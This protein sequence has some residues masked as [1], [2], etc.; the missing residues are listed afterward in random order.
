MRVNASDVIYPTFT[1]AASCFLSLVLSITEEMF[2]AWCSPTLLTLFA[3]SFDL[4]LTGEASYMDWEC[5]WKVL[6][7]SCGDQSQGNDKWYTNINVHTHCNKCTMS[8]CWSVVPPLKLIVVFMM[9]VWSGLQVTICLMPWSPYKLKFTTSTRGR[10]F[11]F[12]YKNPECCL[13]SVLSPLTGS[14]S[15]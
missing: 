9:H 8:Y 10:S 13:N 11:F 5:D 2:A 3:L 6:S 12:S 7:Q 14:K 1:S 4:S 15:V